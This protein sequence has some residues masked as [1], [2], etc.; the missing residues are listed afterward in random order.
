MRLI[1]R[2]FPFVAMLGLLAVLA[3][4]T[5][6]EPTQTPSVGVSNTLG[7]GLSPSPAF[8]DFLG[9]EQPH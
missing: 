5:A 2:L 1:F 3:C 7:N 9:I 4:G 6:E 8:G